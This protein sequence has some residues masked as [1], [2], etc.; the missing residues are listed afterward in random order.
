[1]HKLLELSTKTEKNCINILV[2][3][4]A[5][6]CFIKQGVLLS[7]IL[8]TEGQRSSVQLANGDKFQSTEPCFVPVDFGY[9][10]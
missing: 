1:M 9:H 7:T 5:S 4:G 6:H 8:T 2:V 10:M 3:K